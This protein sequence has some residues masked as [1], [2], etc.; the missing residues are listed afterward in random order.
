M[1]HRIVTVS[2]LMGSGGGYVGYLAAK[3]LGFRY[4]DREILREAAKKLGTDV[5]Q[6]EEIDGRASSLLMNIVR[7]FGMG[8]PE[9]ISQP[10]PTLPVYE[11]DLFDL[12]SRIIR[13]MADQYDAV[14]IGRG[15]FHVLR[16]RAGVIHVFVHAPEEFRVGR[17]MKVRNITDFKSARTLVRE[18]DQRR[19]KF[20]RDMTG[21]D[22]MDARNYHLCVDTSAVGLSACV[23]MI[24]SLVGSSKPH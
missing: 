19:K 12:Q 16:G 1:E 24:V 3:E 7:S 17:V 18:S 10:P 8:A 9:A 14:I 20:I 4:I 6:L 23:E 5:R 13:E 2:R 11:R 15:A 22:W 21:S